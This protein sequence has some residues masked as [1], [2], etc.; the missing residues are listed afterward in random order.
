[1]LSV[2]CESQYSCEKLDYLVTEDGTGTNPNDAGTYERT[3]STNAT[4]DD[5]VV[6]A[7]RREFSVENGGC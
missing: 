5:G 4:T 6:S 3:T 1:M 2:V 7:S